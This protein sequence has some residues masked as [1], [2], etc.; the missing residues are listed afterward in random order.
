MAIYAAPYVIVD[1][2]TIIGD[3]NAPTMGGVIYSMKTVLQSINR[4]WPKL[5]ESQQQGIRELYA[6]DADVISTWDLY[7]ITA[8]ING[9]A[10]V[11]PLKVL[12]LGHSLAVDSG[13]ML[14]LVAD[15]E[16]F[17]QPMEIATLY[18]SGCPL[19]KHVN[20]INQNAGVYQLYVSS[21]TTPDKP[22]VIIK[23][24]TM[25]YG[26][27]YA[28]WDIIIMQGGVFEI[29]EDITYQ[30]GK[31]QFIQD[32]VNQHK[33]NPNAVFAWH[34]AW[35]PPTDNTLRDMYPYSPNTYY[36][37]YTAY[38]D[39]RTTLYNAITGA[40][41]RNI[42]TDD[43]FIYLIPSGTAIENALSSYLVE[44][45]LHRDYAHVTDLGRVIASYTWYCTLAGID[46][47]DEIA[48]DTIPVA[49]FKS[50]TGTTDRVLTDMEKAIILESVNNALANPLQMTQSQYTEAP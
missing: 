48:L 34:M 3:D 17:D 6:M 40:V 29:A 7:N 26:I 38:N 44:S 25:E 47:L 22:P 41:G 14:N 35:A 36:T 21:S 46:H 30:D 9:T 33:T 2:E 31:I 19:Y 15:A 27:E 42:V 43:S 16:G 13:H 37:N 10:A 50:T 18:Y 24:V 45:D 39:D 8:A 23:G 32:Y 4:V 49:F 12:T 28:D 1:G 5:S 11:R 20:F